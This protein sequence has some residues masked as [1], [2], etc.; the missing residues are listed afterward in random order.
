M[1]RLLALPAAGE[2]FLLQ[3][4]GKNILV[5]GSYGYR[6]LADTLG[7]PAIAVRHLDI[8]VCTASDRVLRDLSY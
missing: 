1:D 6:R 5:D 2:S 3:R 4:G 8:V 7:L